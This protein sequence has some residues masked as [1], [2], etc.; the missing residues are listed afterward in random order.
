MCKTELIF[1]QQTFKEKKIRMNLLKWRAR[2]FVIMV[3]NIHHSRR[4]C[5]KGYS[6]FAKPF[7]RSGQHV[8]CYFDWIAETILIFK[9]LSL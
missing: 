6:G 3:W 5:T 2:Q 7:E 8:K 4:N 9:Y 1:E